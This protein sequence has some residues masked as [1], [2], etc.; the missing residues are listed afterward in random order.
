MSYEQNE[1]DISMIERQYEQAPD[2]PYPPRD[3]LCCHHDWQ[4]YDA[5]GN[6]VGDPNDPGVTIRCCDWCGVEEEL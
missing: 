4:H 1:H 6:R 2:E 5:A 3:D